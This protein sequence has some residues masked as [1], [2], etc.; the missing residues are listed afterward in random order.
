MKILLDFTIE[1]DDGYYKAFPQMTKKLLDE[2][3]DDIAG[4]ICEHEEL[5]GF[6]ATPVHVAYRK[7]I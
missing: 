3:A 6:C 4:T 1:I 2:L 5:G 7:A